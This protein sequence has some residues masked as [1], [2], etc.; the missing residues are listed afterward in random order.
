MNR[1]DL[2]KIDLKFDTENLPHLSNPGLM[3]VTMSVGQW[4]TILQVAY[5]MG[6]ILL[7]LDDNEKPVAAY[8]KRI[9]EK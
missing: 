9:I 2:N 6:A 7:E 5:D 3:M 1:P 4:D 8:Q